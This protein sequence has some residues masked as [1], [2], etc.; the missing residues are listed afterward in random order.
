MIESVSPLPSGFVHVLKCLETC[1]CF[2]IPL[3]LLFPKPYALGEVAMEWQFCSKPPDIFDTNIVLV[4][5]IQVQEVLSSRQ[6]L[7]YFLQA[8]HS[9]RREQHHSRATPQPGMGT[10]DPSGCSAPA[11]CQLQVSLSCHSSTFDAASQRNRMI[12]FCDL[13]A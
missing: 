8:H 11:L 3:E 13:L 2:G 1:E 5:S 4:E 12:Q 6:G 7:H 10:G 9:S